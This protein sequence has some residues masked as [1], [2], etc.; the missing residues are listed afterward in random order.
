M[1]RPVLSPPVVG[2]RLERSGHAE[3]NVPIA[4]GSPS[5]APMFSTPTFSDRQRSA[6]QQSGLQSAHQS[7]PQLPTLTLGQ[8]DSV[9]FD[10]SICFVDKVDLGI[11]VFESESFR[12]RWLS[13]WRKE[14]IS[15]NVIN[16][17]RDLVSPFV[18]VPAIGSL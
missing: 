7:A 16:R 6:P 3:Q 15:I 10:V 8:I 9:R 1:C 5:S 13:I 11:L 12:F 4:I 18:S 2:S 14:Y 17:R